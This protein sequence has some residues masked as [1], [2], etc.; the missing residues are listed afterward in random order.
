MKLTGSGG[1]QTQHPLYY[2]DG[3]ITTGGTPQLCLARSMSRSLLI[4]ENPNA[5]GNIYF[6][7]GSARATCTISGGGVNTV[8]ITNAGFGFSYPPVVRFLGGGSAGNPAYKGLAQPN[9]T[10][11]P[12]QASGR[13]L[14]TGNAVSS[15]VIDNPGSGYVIAPYVFIQNSELDPIGAAIPSAT[16]GLMLAPAGGAITFNGTCC[17]TDVISVFS[18]TTGAAYVTR[19]MD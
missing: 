13:A 18:A 14:L 12:N 5:S 19:W 3:T 11:P 17:P 16:S 8:T 7:F 15:I 9:G 4:L 1:Q 10:T 2:A 6:E